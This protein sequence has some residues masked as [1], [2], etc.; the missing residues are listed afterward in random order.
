MAHFIASL[1]GT[2]CY[3][4]GHFYFMAIV[5]KHIRNDTNEVFYIGIG[6]DESRAHNKCNRSSYWK[7]IV[8]KYGYNI[9]LIEKDISWETACELEKQL[10]KEY[11]R[12]DLGFGSLI[13]MTDGGDGQSNP[14]KETRD[15][16]RKAKIGKS[17]S[18]KTIDKI[19]KSNIGKK[20]GPQTNEHKQKLREANI[21]NNHSENS[22]QKMRQAKLG[23][24]HSEETKRKI[25]EVKIGK[26]LSPETIEKMIQSR[27]GKKRGPYKKLK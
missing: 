17:L 6:N 27:I 15:K 18:D 24:S 21:G 7:G 8:K 11:G 19:K 13:N 4:L 16:M 26:K 9:E 12:A 22:K 5:Y 14:S 23:T 25:S 1:L 3:D 2:V 10:I 20:R